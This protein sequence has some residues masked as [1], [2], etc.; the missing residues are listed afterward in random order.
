MD[1]GIGRHPSY[2]TIFVC[3]INSTEGDQMRRV[4]LQMGVTIDGYVAGLNGNSGYGLPPEHPD[5]EAW[6]VASLQR[7]GTHIMGRVTYE[8]MARHWP[9][10]TGDYAISMN[11]RPKTVFSKTLATAQWSG[12]RI[13]RGELA[14][15]IAA[16]K[17][18]DGGEIMAHGGADFVQALSRQRLIDEYRLVILPVA[19][20]NGLP[21]F[22]DLPRPMQLSVLSSEHFPDGTV[23]TVYQPAPNDV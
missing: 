21:L 10:S 7:V 23:I 1:A 18:E 14:D 8:Q 4:V 22:K 16:L 12:T 17:A 6:K 9:K 3:G 20:G 2:S 19:I 5:V 11:T 15:E 13:A